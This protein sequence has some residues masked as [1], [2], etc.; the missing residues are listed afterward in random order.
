M[1]SVAGAATLPSVMAELLARIRLPLAMLVLLLAAPVSR[2]M[3]KSSAM[4]AVKVGLTVTRLI[5]VV[6]VPVAAAL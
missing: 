2:P 6:A 3:D 4:K 5:A 1:F